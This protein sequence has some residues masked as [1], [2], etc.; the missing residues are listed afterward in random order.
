MHEDCITI[1]RLANGPILRVSIPAKLLG[2]H[3]AEVIRR[4]P[5]VC[6]LLPN[7]NGVAYGYVIGQQPQPLNILICISV[8]S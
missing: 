5:M 4:G 8:T 3:S 7:A 2:S 6:L 1:S